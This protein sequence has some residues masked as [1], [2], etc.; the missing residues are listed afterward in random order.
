[1]VVKVGGLAEQVR[2]SE[3]VRTIIQD[4]IHSPLF[5][6]AQPHEDM[7]GVILSILLSDTSLPFFI[8]FCYSLLLSVSPRCA[9]AAPSKCACE[10]GEIRLR[11]AMGRRSRRAPQ[12]E[13]SF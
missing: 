11:R 9:V 7:M 1:M 2:I 13:P 12:S 6:P 3:Q 4:Q 10:E 5:T 8:S